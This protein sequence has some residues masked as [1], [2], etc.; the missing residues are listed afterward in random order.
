M[1]ADKATPQGERFSVQAWHEY[2]KRKFIG[3]EEVKLP[4]GQTMTIA[5]SSADL[6]VDEFSTYVTKVE[7]WAAE[8][9]FY[10][11]ELPA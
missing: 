4:N 1:V 11:D 2:L 10:L 5:H 9:G 8:H 3:A 6:S 7:A